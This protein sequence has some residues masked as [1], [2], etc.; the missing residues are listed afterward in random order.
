MSTRVA[1]YGHF[2]WHEHLTTDPNAA[3]AFYGDVIGW[4][5]QP[6]GA[7]N[8][9][10]MMWVGSQGP[11]GGVMKLPEKARE[12]GTPPHWIGNV[13]VHNVDAIVARV[14][15]L[16]GT[17][18][19]AASDVP[20]AGRFA[21]VADPQGAALV[22]LKPIGSMSL[23]DAS[24]EGEFCWNELITTESNAAVTFYSELFGWTMMQELN[25][26]AMGTH[27]IFGIGTTQ[28]GG[29]MDIPS[30]SPLQAAWLYHVATK[31]MDAALARATAQ[32][33]KV[34]NGPRN[35]PGGR[36]VQLVDPQGAVFALCE[37]T[38][39]T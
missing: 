17:L 14:E 28:L 12:A 13:M 32:G 38:P 36:A 20:M 31:D 11:L 22:V 19:K 29:I 15:Q 5:T 16:G 3:V 25:M 37:M 2:V 10:Y 24:R 1:R 8:S 30:G 26:G 4:K 18:L 7:N 35:V 9:D 23:H 33:A 21:V 39:S 34:L 27:R 6:F